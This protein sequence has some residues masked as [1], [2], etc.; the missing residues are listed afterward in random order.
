[1][2]YDDILKTRGAFGT[3]AALI[4]RLAQLR[5][6]LDLSAIVAELNPGALPGMEQLQRTLRILTR[7]VMPFR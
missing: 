5:D 7:E 1:M 3:A 6:G 4:D 2:T